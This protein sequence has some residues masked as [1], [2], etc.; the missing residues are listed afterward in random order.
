MVF[1]STRSDGEHEG[2]RFI[3]YA[4]SLPD[5]NKSV[6]P[7]I[8]KVVGVFAIGFTAYYLKLATDESIKQNSAKPISIKVVKQAGGWGASIAG[9][10]IGMAAG[11]AVG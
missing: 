11:A 6:P 3:Y 5:V 8:V 9:G 7:P 1:I 2:D 4:D 10:R